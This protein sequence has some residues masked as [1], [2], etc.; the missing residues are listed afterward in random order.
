M[1]FSAAQLANWLN[2]SA[3]SPPCVAKADRVFGLFDLELLRVGTLEEKAR[4]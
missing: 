3:T 2:E 1:S 4:R